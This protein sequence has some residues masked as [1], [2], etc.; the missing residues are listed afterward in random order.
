MV[1][2]EKE[3]VH[4]AV[5]TVRTTASRTSPLMSA[6]A[7]GASPRARASAPSPRRARTRAECRGRGPRPPRAT[8]WPAASTSSSLSA[9]SSMTTATYPSPAVDS[10]ARACWEVGSGSTKGSV[11]EATP[12]RSD[13]VRRGGLAAGQA[14]EQAFDASAPE[15]QRGYD[16]GEQRHMTTTLTGRRETVRPMRMNMCSVAAANGREDKERRACSG[17][18]ARLHTEE[19]NCFQLQGKL[20][21]VASASQPSTAAVSRRVAWPCPPAWEPGRPSD[22]CVN[23][24]VM[25]RSTGRRVRP[26][27]W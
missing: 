14:I 19:I 2:A 22:H 23:G 21:I 27:G 11:T 3:T 12:S 17:A 7:G 20:R 4:P 26:S 18:H 13:S 5:A 15:N 25:I 9:A 16:G 8:R 10:N 24:A 1:S 6:L